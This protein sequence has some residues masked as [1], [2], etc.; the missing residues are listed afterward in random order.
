M[1]KSTSTS[2]CCVRV[3]MDA[4][5]SSATALSSLLSRLERIYYGTALVEEARPA[6]AALLD[7]RAAG[8]QAASSKFA[9]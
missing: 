3:Q 1:R 6:V 4:A 9:A 7:L 2:T 5:P 8:W